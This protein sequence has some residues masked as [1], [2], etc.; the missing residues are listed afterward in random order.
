VTGSTASA[1]VV[2]LTRVGCHLCADAESV[3]RQVAHDVGVAWESK[4]VDTDPALVAQWG[5]YVPVVFVD[6]AVHTWF[7][8]DPERLRTAVSR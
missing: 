4:D 6:G 3:V 5:E 7:R 8:V 2:V 1:R